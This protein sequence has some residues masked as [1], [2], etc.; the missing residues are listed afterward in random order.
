[1]SLTEELFLIH[2]FFSDGTD[3]N[4]GN[5]MTAS[6]A[7]AKTKEITNSYDC[8][9]GKIS[10]VIITDAGDGCVFEWWHGTGVVFPPSSEAV[11][12]ASPAWQVNE[13]IDIITT[14]LTKPTF[15]GIVV[16]NTR[17]VRSLMYVIRITYISGV[18]ED[19]VEISGDKILEEF[20]KAIKRV[21]DPN[22]PVKNFTVLEGDKVITK[23]HYVNG[24]QVTE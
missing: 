14:G 13:M 17:M 3:S 7:V 1:M 23:C 5:W 11:N 12:K 8:M 15:D 2:T 9:I 16:G 21:Q 10:K 4:D 18:V 19:S 20:G 22:N 24:V 6:E